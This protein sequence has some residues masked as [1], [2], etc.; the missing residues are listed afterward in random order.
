MLGVA[1]EVA[2]ILGREVKFPAVE[3]K[4]QLKK[5]LII[6]VLKLKQKKIIRYTSRKLLKM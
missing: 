4:K 3:K 1:Y 5:H 2:A 6:F